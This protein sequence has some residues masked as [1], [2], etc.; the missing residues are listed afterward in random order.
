[1]NLS[2]NQISQLRAVSFWK[3][4]FLAFAFAVALL[5][6]YF[7]ILEPMKLEKV[8]VEAMNTEKQAVAISQSTTG[9]IMLSDGSRTI[10]V[11]VQKLCSQMS[12]NGGLK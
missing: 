10:F 12:I 2:K 6:I 8:K 1:M 5:I 9:N 7:I 3:G 4:M 11:P